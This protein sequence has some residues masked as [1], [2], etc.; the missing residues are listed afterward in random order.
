MKKT[1]F[2]Q[3]RRSVKMPTDRSL[4]PA[5]RLQQSAGAWSSGGSPPSWRAFNQH[6][7]HFSV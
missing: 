2:I 3:R 7:C 1:V 5:D 6:R 4:L